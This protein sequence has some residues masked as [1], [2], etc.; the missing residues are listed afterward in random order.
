MTS[1]TLTIPSHMTN[2]VRQTLIDK[3]REFEAPLP[4]DV[5]PSD[6]AAKAWKENARLLRLMA[7]QLR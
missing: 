5:E 4:P 7:G 6:T 2:L 1:R 3:A